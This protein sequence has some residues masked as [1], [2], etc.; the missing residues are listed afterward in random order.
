V[1]L[2]AIAP[3][4]VAESAAPGLI[5]ATPV[6]AGPV[7][8]QHTVSVLARQHRIRIGRPL[9][10]AAAV[11]AAFA[12]L[13]GGAVWMSQKAL[14]GDALY[15]L[16]RASES[17]ELTTAGST[18]DRAKDYL[19]FA[20]TRADEARTLLSRATGDRPQASVLDAQT[21]GLISSVLV[22]ADHDVQSAS[23]L[24]GDQAV[25]TNSTS[26]LS[27]MTDWAPGQLTRLRTLADAMPDGPLRAR[28]ES[29]AQL[30]ARAHLRA[31]Q[32]AASVGNG[33]IT[34]ANRD[35]L[36]PLPVRSCATGTGT[37]N[38]P[39]KRGHPA[40]TTHR[41]VSNRVGAG[42]GRGGRVG[43][44]VGSGRGSGSRV[45]GGGGA[46][47]GAPQPNRSAALHPIASP[48]RSR[49]PIN[50][51]PVSLPPPPT[52]LPVQVSSCSLQVSV[53]PLGINVGVCP[54]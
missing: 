2:V 13:F 9:A 43:G 20:Q 5:D 38:T 32:L 27:I 29:A 19:K 23:T 54:S 49:L 52:S 41:T 24:L 40:G 48:A 14:P 18:T 4:L 42:A 3:R 53:G 26:P 44:G 31:Q 50:I 51:P 21:D 16:K 10:I 35:E 28:T 22:S 25:A 17:W 37:S 46:S 34:S 33:C 45:G 6:R 8:P 30:V 39:K 36:G 15:G 1:Q 7:Q 11:V 12:L 47:S